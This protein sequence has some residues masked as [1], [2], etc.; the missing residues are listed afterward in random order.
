MAF[1]L[2]PAGKVLASTGTLVNDGATLLYRASKHVAGCERCTLASSALLQRSHS[3]LG[4]GWNSSLRFSAK[5]YGR[6]KVSH[7]SHS[8]MRCRSICFCWL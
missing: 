8:A 5:M 1:Y 7:S 4:A 6:L 2:C 3:S